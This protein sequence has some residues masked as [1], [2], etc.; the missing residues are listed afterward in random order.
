MS[1]EQVRLLA[2]SGG[3]TALERE[4]LQAGLDVG[5]P[6]SAKSE[7]WAA[8]SARL[9]PPAPVGPEP[10]TASATS[11]AGVWKIGLLGFATGALVAGALYLATPSGDP[12]PA[13]DVARPT[14]LTES[15]TPAQAPAPELPE[16]RSAP[17]N[18]PAPRKV[19]PAAP[20]LSTAPIAP[21]A[22]E[23]AAA[24]L[25]AQPHDLATSRQSQ[26]REESRLLREARTALRSGSP[27]RAL[28]VLEESRAKHP[29]MVLGQEHEA[30]SVE[31]LVA[32][33]S[34]AAA[35]ARARAFIARFPTSPH[36]TKLR[37]IAEAP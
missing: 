20:G 13:A 9:P 10:A 26:L 1:D 27:A 3:T 4:L 30:L 22:T 12:A 18:K 5:P 6:P 17:A 31:A 37:S 7:V 11:T 24:A 33:G 28:S 29:Q 32:S 23:A 35:R 19:A 36:V 34:R 15:E 14:A 21:T 16:P 2:E 25:P 8:L